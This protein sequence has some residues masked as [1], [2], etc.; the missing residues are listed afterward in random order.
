MGLRLRRPDLGGATLHHRLIHGDHFAIRNLNEDLPVIGSI[1]DPSGDH[2]RR[3]DGRF[4]IRDQV[5]L[6]IPTKRARCQTAVGLS[7][8]QLDFE[9]T[10]A[11]KRTESVL[12]R[13]RNESAI[14]FGHDLNLSA[15]MRIGWTLGV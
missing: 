5:T 12:A 9:D 13:K 7:V 8:G 3:L 10:F 1:D 6:V 2:P 4:L 14:R 11:R 15:T